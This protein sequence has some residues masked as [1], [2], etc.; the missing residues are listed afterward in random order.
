ME[1]NKLIAEF[2]GIKGND[3]DSYKDVYTSIPVNGMGTITVSVERM[4]FHRDWNWLMPVVDKIEQLNNITEFTIFGDS[5]KYYQVTI[6]QYTINK[7]ITIANIEGKDKLQSVYT[8]V[9]EFIKW[10]NSHLCANCGRFDDVVGTHN[11]TICEE[12]ALNNTVL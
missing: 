5:R 11:I 7:R 6:K 9:I 10:Y 12:C 1:N 4:K 8:A 3:S 2:I